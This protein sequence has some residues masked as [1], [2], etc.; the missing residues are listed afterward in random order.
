M[1]RHAV[2]ASLDGTEPPPAEVLFGGEELD[3]GLRRSLARLYLDGEYLKLLSER[4]LSG[5]LHGRTGPEGALLKL[6]WSEVSQRAA[7]IAGEV[8]GPDSL[9]GTAGRDLVDAR[10]LSIRTRNGVIGV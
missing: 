1:Y 10:S 4:A 3:P 7:E 9:R 5:G 2:V 8:L 6:V